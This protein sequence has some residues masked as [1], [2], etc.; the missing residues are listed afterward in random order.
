MRTSPFA[1]LVES[2]PVAGNLFVSK[3]RAR[4][5]RM[6]LSYLWLFVPGLV[7]MIGFMA[8]RSQK[9]MLVGDTGI[10][11]GVYVLTG[12]V[13][14][15]SVNDAIAMP[16]AQLGAHRRF[17]F[18]AAVPHEVVLLAGL[19]E[20][21]FN[22]AIRLILLFIVALIAG[23]PFAPSWALVPLATLSLTLLGLGVGLCLA[24]Y[25]L[26]FDDV[27]RAITLFSSML[28]LVT[29]IVYTLPPGSPLALNPLVPALE[30]ARAWLAG[31]FPPLPLAL[32]IQVLAALALIGFGWAQYRLARPH[33]AARLG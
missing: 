33:L 26:L 1:D 31:E 4:H 7:V 3:M 22:S 9:V 16:I 6:I 8:I 28:L 5:R 12:M 11:Y 2:I 20:V 32:L 14:W 21:L 15:Q 19:G 13:L 18:R 29:P 10:P 23:M 30:V 24:P 25:G 17:L 27:G